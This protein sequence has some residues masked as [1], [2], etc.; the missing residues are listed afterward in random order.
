MEVYLMEHSFDIGHTDLERGMN[1]LSAV[2]FVYSLGIAFGN[3]SLAIKT[4]DLDIH[5]LFLTTI[6]AWSA[7]AAVIGD[8]DDI[9]IALHNIRI[10]HHDHTVRSVDANAIYACT[11]GKHQAV[12]G[13]E[14]TELAGADLHIQHNA[15]TH[16]LIEVCPDEGQPCVAAHAAGAL[17]GTIA[18]RTAAE[19]QDH[20]FRSEHGLRFLLTLQ[21]PCTAPTVENTL[22]VHIENYICQI[23]NGLFIV[24]LLIRIPMQLAHSLEEQCVAILFVRCRS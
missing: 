10:I 8:S 4:D 17:K 14:L 1:M 6:F 12:V 2:G 5:P 3:E 16:T 9:Y 20:A 24:R 23:G 19:V 11:T 22:E 15:L 21:L 7:L 13:V 18:V